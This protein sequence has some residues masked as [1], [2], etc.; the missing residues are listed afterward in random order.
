MDAGNLQ[1]VL[2]GLGVTQCSNTSGHGGAAEALAFRAR[3][4]DGFIGIFLLMWGV[5][6]TVFLFDCIAF[7]LFRGFRLHRPD[8]D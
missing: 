6:Y 8:V 4:E 7:G 5:W 3:G 1:S 2:L